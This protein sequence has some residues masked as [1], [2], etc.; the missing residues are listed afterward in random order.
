MKREKNIFT[1]I[2][3]LVV[4]AII[5]ILAAM[6]L[7]ALNQARER[8]K[9]ASCLNNLKQCGLATQ[10]YLDDHNGYV[11]HMTPYSMG[12]ALGSLFR[13]NLEFKPSGYFSD[14]KDKTIVCPKFESYRN[15]YLSTS[16]SA[17]DYYRVSYGAIGWDGAMGGIYIQSDPSGSMDFNSKQ[18]KIPSSLFLLGDAYKPNYGYPYG[19][20][21]IENI[22][23]QFSLCHNGSGNSLF[24]DG[25]AE[26]INSG[27]KFRE[28]YDREYIARD[29]R[30]KST[31][32]VIDKN[33]FCRPF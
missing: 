24:L 12:W 1:L 11:W 19:A 16:L 25:H 18:V 21:F 2:E 8:A 31:V 23:N 22:T 27:E 10:S 20:M 28:I 4:I 9:A 29:L 13:V 32:Y 3:L 5:A 33:F 26:A 17:N 14:L 30:K 7:P 6:L 15:Q